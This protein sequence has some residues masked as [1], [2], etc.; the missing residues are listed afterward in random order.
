MNT[1]RLSGIRSVLGIDL[2]ENGLRAVELRSRGGLLNKYHSEYEVVNAFSVEFE[3]A[4]TSE[5]KGNRLAR[6][7]QE[8]KIKTRFCVS[9]IN[10]TTA[11]TVTAEIPSDVPVASPED[12]ETWIR[13]KYEK[14]IRVPIQLSELAFAYEILPSADSQPRRCK[15]SFVRES[16]RQEYTSLFAAARL[17]LLNLGLSDSNPSNDPIIQSLCPRGYEG[18]PSVALA[19][20]GFLPELGS[21][22]FLPEIERKKTTEEKDKS[23]FYRVVLALGVVLF[24]LLGLQFGLNTYFQRESDKTDE[25]LLQVGPVYSEVT[26][27]G[28]QVS[29]LKSELTGGGGKRS[30]V[31]KVLHDIA[32][33]T[34]KGVWLYKLDVTHSEIDLFGYAKSNELAASYLG[35]LQKN[36]QFSNVQ[37]IRVGTPT[38]SESVSFENSGIKSVTTFE[39]KMK[40]IQSN[41]GGT[42]K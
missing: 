33:S 20:M 18:N 24:V 31:A 23:L 9:S 14:F 17:H 19:I 4:L 2:D 36:R 37:V 16:E 32:E 35:L 7:L 29:A 12:V 1:L 8:R 27:L 39:L 3:K 15:I 5:E 13:E 28:K 34:P 42:V 40:H 38:E 22:D 30:S 25:Q 6:E 26:T 10:S 11:R 41:A 21:M